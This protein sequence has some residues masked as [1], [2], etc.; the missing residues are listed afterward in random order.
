MNYLFNFLKKFLGFVMN[1]IWPKFCYGCGNFANRYIC[2]NCFLKYVFFNKNLKCIVCDQI[3]QNGLTH[4]ECQEFTYVDQLLVFSKYQGVIAQML[5]DGKY[6][7]VF[8]VY[9]DFAIYLYKHF[10]SLVANENL[11][12]VPVPLHK[13]KFKDRGFN[14]AG[15]LAKSLSVL[16][17]MPF[18]D[19]I[20]R[21][22]YTDSQ[23]TKNKSDR[24]LDLLDAFTIKRFYKNNLPNKIILVDDILTTGSTLNACAKILKDNG[25]EFVLSIVIA[26][27][28]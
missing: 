12:F 16:F 19:C 7:R 20:E 26:S 9:K 27:E 2:K 1:L 23:T 8:D 6:S 18:L 4:K 17:N 22:K 24:F 10:H 28:R 3:S 5:K 21:K 13:N 15:I 14:Q 25:C 11:V